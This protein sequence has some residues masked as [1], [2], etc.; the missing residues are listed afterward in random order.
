MKYQRF[1]G[2]LL[3]ALPGLFGCAYQDRESARSES[4]DPIVVRESGFGVVA[5]VAEPDRSREWLKAR[6][7]SRLD[8][9]RNLAERVYG[10][11]IYGGSTVNEF[12]LEN[13]LF[14]A[15]VDSSIRGAE[16]VAVYERNGGMIETI[17]ELQLEPQSWACTAKVSPAAGLC[18]PSPTG[19][20]GKGP[21]ARADAE[22]LYFLE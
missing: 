10:T 12:V 14:R 13:D 2:W 22:K 3:I 19:L 1:L 18:L 21:D 9:Y 15:Y 8:A 4:P 7:A 11:V 17:L 5:N 16:V 6:R 20:S